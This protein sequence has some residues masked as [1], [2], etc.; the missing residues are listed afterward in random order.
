MKA[1]VGADLHIPFQCNNTLKAFISHCKDKDLIVLNGDTMDFYGIS[2]FDSSPNRADD[3]EYEL[4]CG[5]GVLEQIRNINSKAEIIFIMGNHEERLSKFL[6]R[7]KNKALFNLSCLKIENL[8]NFEKYR[9]QLVNNIYHLN[10]NF[11]ITHGV[12]CG[13]EPAKMEAQR[14]MISGL[15]GHAHKSSV[16]IRRY[17]NKTIKWYSAP[18][19]CDIEQM[20]YAAKFR[21]AWTKGFCLIDY[22]KNN[23]KVEEVEITHG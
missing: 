12:S 17:L 8:L 22:D 13:N 7:G 20:D 2:K 14:Y 5:R 4:T 19:M 6:S 1:I 3:L 21:H 16:F 11:I 23:F 18:C 9:I 15:S 10:K